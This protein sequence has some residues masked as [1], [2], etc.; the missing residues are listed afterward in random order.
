MNPPSMHADFISSSAPSRVG[1][2]GLASAEH[3][4]SDWAAFTSASDLGE[5]CRS[6]LAI[7]CRLIPGVLGAVVLT[8]LPGSEVLSLV[9]S[10]PDE[11]RD[12]SHLSDVAQQAVTQQRG[13]VLPQPALAAGAAARTFVGYPIESEGQSWAVVALDATTRT[14]LQMQAALRQL[15]WGASGLELMGCRQALA[16]S[17]HAQARQ[18]TVLEV[19]ATA[20]EHERYEAAATA[21]A[22]ELAT[23]LSCSRVSLG[24]AHRAGCRVDAVS[25]SAQFKERTDLMRAVAAAMDEAVDQRASVAVPAPVGRAAT[26]HR[27][28]DALAALGSGACCTV[29]L[30][31]WGSAVGAIT[32]ERQVGEPFDAAA[33]ELCEAVAALAGPW[34][35]LHRRE[36]RGWIS[37]LAD[38]VRDTLGALLGP[39]H[40]TAK[41][42]S[43]GTLGVLAFLLLAQGEFRV[44]AA[45]VL[46]PR[47]QLA[48]TSPIAGYIK[49][50]PARA[51]D[52]VKRG[53]LLARLDD[54]DLQIERL[55]WSSQHSELSKTQRQAFAER[56]M[57]QMQIIGAQLEQAAAQIARA[58]EQLGRTLVTAPFDG[59]VVSGD[60]S[61]KLGSPIE[62]GAVLFEVAP[63]GEFRLVLKV[64][65]SDI[66]FIRTGQRGT[67]LNAA[68]PNE[69]IGF[70]VTAVTP[71]ANARDGRNTF[72][73]EAQV[74]PTSV[75]I[76]PNM[77]GVGKVDIERRSLLWIW[78]RQ[79]VN[80]VRL[81]AWSWLP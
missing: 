22:T 53:A 71:V 56:N 76:R 15:H 48:A 49:E 67:L 1:R 5:Y 58:D 60:L 50:A 18:H 19:L 32:L 31:T 78:T 68:L 80:A 77:E 70:A 42:I 12:M 10:W 47:V 35:D 7:Q 27:A 39:R 40:W 69:P 4:E 52:L 55:K 63:L 61:Q 62:R 26:L 57:A 36:N 2:I 3:E 29:L 9:A 11:R 13:V 74:D 41:L 64:D 59:M 79:T 28:H 65:E 72:R 43:L 44:S 8:K 66:A 20:S 81:M 24:F 45:T 73:V 75:G 37:R 54:R 6:W 25:H 14:E 16:Q 23:R 17:Q 51:G 33:L 30:P 21:L 38:G 46:E 34:L